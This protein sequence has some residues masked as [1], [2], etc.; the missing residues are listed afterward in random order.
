MPSLGVLLYDP[1]KKLIVK[2]NPHRE[3]FPYSHYP[4]KEEVKRF[5]LYDTIVDPTVNVSVDDYSSMVFSDLFLSNF[6]KLTY[7]LPCFPM[8]N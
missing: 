8:D 6:A 1:T 3:G 5:Y 4:C 2:L 7:S